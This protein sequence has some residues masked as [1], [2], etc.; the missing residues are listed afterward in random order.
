LC[1][2]LVAVCDLLDRE[3]GDAGSG[4]CRRN[5]EHISKLRK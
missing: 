4:C 5:V 1:F 2:L 3:T